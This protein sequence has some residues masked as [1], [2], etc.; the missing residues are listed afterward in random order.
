MKTRLV[1]AGT[2]L[3]LLLLPYVAHAEYRAYELE[4]VDTLD[5]KLNKR[6]KCKSSRI[7]TA[8]SPDLYIQT[9]GGDERINAVVLAT[10][11]CY[12]DTSQYREVCSRPGPRSPKF[13]SGEDVRVTLKK[14]ITEGWRGKVELVYRDD[15][16]SANVVGVRF[17][18]HK[19]VY[20]R[21][22]EKD[23]AK[24]DA[25]APRAEPPK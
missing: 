6:D 15:F 5:C 13:N 22:F 9:N 20:A 12:G 23:L 4:V 8:M 14:H 1:L 18:D 19:N 7:T 21:Y 25:Q 11:M 17:P 2:L 3:A 16:L 10:W 24:P